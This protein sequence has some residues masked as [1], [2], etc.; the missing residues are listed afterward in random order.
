[1]KKKQK[2]GHRKLYRMVGKGFLIMRLFL[3]L[4]IVGVLHST[5]SVSQTKRL[6]LNEKNISVKEVLILIEK[7][8]GYRFFY[9]DTKINVNKKL[10]IDMDNSTIEEVLNQLSEK[11]GIEY[12]VMDNNFVVLKSSS[13]G[14]RFTNVQQNKTVTGKVTDSSGAPLPGV[15]VIVKGT[16]QGA[17]TTFEGNYTISTVPAA[18]TLVFSFVG[19]RTQEIYLAGKTNINVVM[20]EDAIGIEEVV[21]I[22]YGTMKKQAVTGA[23]SKANIE[24]YRNVPVNNIMESIKGSV[25]GLS[26]DGVNK[27]GQVGGI[28]IR[29][30]NSTAGNNPLIVLDGTIFSGSLADIPAEDIENLI[31]L[32]DASAAAVYGSRSANGVILLET[33]RGTG[34]NGKPKFDV[35]MSYGI[36]DELK[37]LEVY[38][39]DGYLQKL[40]D[41]RLANGLEADPDKIP[42]YLQPEEQ[43]NYEATPDH[44]PTLKDPYSLIGQLGLTYNTTV[45]VSNK[46]EKT[47]YYISTSFIKQRGVII[48][49]DFKHISGRV[50][51]DSDLTDWFNLGIKSFYSLR[52]YSGS[53]PDAGSERNITFFSPWASVYNE[54]GSY[55]QFPQTT[56][57]FNSPFWYIASEDHELY[58]NLNG[59]ITGVVKVPWIKGLTYNVTYSN[60]IR[61]KENFTFFNENT[62]DG[63]GKNGIGKRIYDR[64]YNM[65]LD[66]L[67]KY[68]N[69][70]NKKHNV[71]LT[72][73]YSQEHSSW[74]NMTGYAEGFDNT[75]LGSYK[76]ENGKTQTVDT[77]GGETDGIGL[78]ARGTYTYNYKYSITG[79]IRRDGY[80]AFSKNKKW[81]V[82]PSVG[83]NWNLSRE[84]FM[85]NITGINNLALRA[86]YGTN[87]NQSIS[88][89]STLAR[90]GTDKYIFYGDPSYTITQYISTLANEDLGWESTTGLNFGIDFA[91]FKRRLS[92]SI[93]GYKTKTN[94]LMFALALP[95]TSG[96]TS[97]TSNIGEI[98]NK[99]FEINMHSVN[100]E[101]ADFRWSSDYAFSL[102]RNKVVTI[103]GDDNDGDGIEDDLISSGYYIGRSLGTI[104]DY[105]VIGM[106]QQEDKDAGT[107]MQGMRP[108]DYML[109]DVN[110]DG[111]ITSEKDRQ[112]LGNSKENFRWSWTNTFEYKNFSLMMYFYSIWGG[113]GWFLSGNNTP[114]LDGYANRGDINH[115]VYDYWT[116]ENTGAE[117]PRL[118]YSANAAYKGK[119]YIDRSFI[120]LQKVSLTYNASKLVRPWGINGLSLSCSADNLFTY[121][122]H[123]EGLDPETNN[124]LSSSSIPSIRTCLFTLSL[125]F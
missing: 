103:L 49:D 33:K 110:N 10:D 12:M 45:S 120:K 98:Q 82:F 5:A 96:K 20:A 54:D 109:E 86:S 17:V 97:I 14:E 27:A 118:D 71:D 114:Y 112:F 36:S 99:G 15:T 16:A 117:F 76:L 69:T 58:N 65:L 81:G 89:Y 124:G 91:L 121:A 29:G 52:D 18:A 44:Q 115:P 51:I 102:N 68:N 125:N 11:T 48:N 113:N 92:G 41:Y 90:M 23:V 80:S 2:S 26:I 70:F 104:Y 84:G 74:E 13:D 6:S 7:Q 108:G 63:K 1:M 75:V 57:S 55:K 53:S 95:S 19:M 88:A 106:W 40:L 42:I 22:G 78:M 25:A 67:I 35:K 101:K 79:T 93:D 43:K 38:D 107:I 21:A 59:I 111:A 47:S 37:Q 28:N 9:E 100:V 60:T 56:T 85:E 105:K 3:F 24:P 4:M 123:W 66:N 39:A 46:T 83:V 32:K 73:L 94:D 61:W 30:Q 31:V 72:L 116:P 8:S 77:G 87:G 34:I 50:N 62:V 64:T 119:K 122:P